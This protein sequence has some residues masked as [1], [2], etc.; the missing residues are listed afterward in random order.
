MIRTILSEDEATGIARIRFEHN[1]VTVE[2]NFA[3]INIVPGTQYVLNAMGL[4]FNEDFKNRALDYLENAMRNGIESGAIQN[5]PPVEENVYVA[6][7]PP[8][9]P[10][11]PEEPEASE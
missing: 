10:D 6:P 7:T 8:T 5:P 4:E 11:Q 1:D 2:D 9:E 3:L